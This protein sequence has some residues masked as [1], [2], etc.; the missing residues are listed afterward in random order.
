MKK[1]FDRS[2]LLPH[3]KAETEEHLRILNRGILALEKNVKDKALIESLLRT[4]HTLKGSSVIAGFARIVDLAH[5]FEDAL[6]RIK[7]GR[8]K[9]GEEHFE[10]LFQLL[11]SISPLL[12]DK[13]FWPQKGVEPPYVTHL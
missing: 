4:A 12:E 10:L 2:L 3:F 11:D 6:V 13:V 9:V 8:L 1:K 5:K 7:E